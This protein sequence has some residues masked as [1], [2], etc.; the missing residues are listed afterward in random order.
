MSFLT[1]FPFLFKCHDRGKGATLKEYRS[2][3]YKNQLGTQL[4]TGSF[5][6]SYLHTGYGLRRYREV[7]RFGRFRHWR[8]YQEDYSWSRSDSRLCGS[9]DPSEQRFDKVG[10]KR[11]HVWTYR[12]DRGSAFDWSRN[13]LGVYRRF[14]PFLPGKARISP[15]ERTRG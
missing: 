11:N 2:E 15:L 9:F 8:F 6:Y 10:R 4:A 7:N 13:P 12:K 14:R 1:L 5:I 3:L